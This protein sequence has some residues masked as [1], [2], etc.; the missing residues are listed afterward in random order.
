VSPWSERARWMLDH[1]GLA[2]QKIE[3]IPFLGERRL[4]KVLGNPAGRVTVP[5]LIADGQTLADSWEIALYAERVGQGTKLIAEELA[6][7]VRRW[8]DLAE[9]SL[10]A[11]RA[12]T[13][14]SLLA[15]DAALEEMLPP[16]TPRLARRLLR[17]VARRATRWFVSKYKLDLEATAQAQGALR[18]GLDAV[19]SA[20]VR[21]EYVLGRFSY[22]DII[23]ASLLQGVV[24]VADRYLRL[25]PATRS[26][27]TRP[28]LAASYSDLVAWR[29]RLYER[30]RREGAPAARVG[31]LA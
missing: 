13:I 31:S 29:D 30:Y 2:F 11:G 24:P 17:P 10:S 26:A 7:D 15:N 8:H 23:A 3:H 27:W 4:R 25:G 14:A 5:V 12:L 19:R 1:H 22:A 9:R 21:T 20:L 6:A 16:A 18:E 28:D